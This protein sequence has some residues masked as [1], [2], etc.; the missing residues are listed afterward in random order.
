MFL[1]KTL[2]LFDRDMYCHLGVT[3]PHYMFEKAWI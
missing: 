1:L 2:N 3:V